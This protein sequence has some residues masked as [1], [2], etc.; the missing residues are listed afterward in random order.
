M[1][2]LDTIEC[3][4]RETTCNKGMVCSFTGPVSIVI[5]KKNMPIGPTVSV[6]SIFEYEGLGR[7]KRVG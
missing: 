6:I 1:L 4:V 2:N 7:W 5:Y 3:C